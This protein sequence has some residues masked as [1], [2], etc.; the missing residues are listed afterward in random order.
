M[1]ASD[2]YSAWGVEINETAASGLLLSF[3]GFAQVK[4][5]I[6]IA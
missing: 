4:A 6:V 3:M 1:S 2:R 5:K